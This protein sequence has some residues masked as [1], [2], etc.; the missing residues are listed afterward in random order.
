MASP[1]SATWTVAEF[2]DLVERPLSLTPAAQHVMVLDRADDLTP[3]LADRLLLR[4]EDPSAPT[5]WLLIVA[6]V[7]L[8]PVT[9]RSRLLDVV[10]ADDDGALFDDAVPDVC[11]VRDVCAAVV[12]VV[13][14]LAAAAGFDRWV[15][16]L[17]A[18][19]V[20]PTVVAA[21]DVARATAELVRAARL[22]TGPKRRFELAVCSTLTD[23]W[24]QRAGV[25]LLD[26]ADPA[27]VTELVERSAAALAA[28]RT[29]ARLETQLVDVA[30]VAQ[31]AHTLVPAT[32]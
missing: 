25:L 24:C 12:D 17:V 28:V 11:E 7:S 29:F 30:L 18:A 15:E 21:S 22:D 6:D 16:R 23:R 5:L 2:V 20:Q 3:A 19:A 13:D 9:V 10:A 1:V 27:A 32:S 8:L 4:L 31:R 26:G 14:E